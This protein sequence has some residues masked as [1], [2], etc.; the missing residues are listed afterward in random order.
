MFCYYRGGVRIEMKG[1][2]MVHCTQP[3][4]YEIVSR[5]FLQKLSFLSVE[6]GTQSTLELARSKRNIFLRRKAKEVVSN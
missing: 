5:N 6:L 1:T 3:Q 2:A 4:N